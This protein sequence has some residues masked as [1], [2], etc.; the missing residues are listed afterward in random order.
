MHVPAQF[1]KF[2]RGIAQL[3][4]HY[5]FEDD[6]KPRAGTGD[7]ELPARPAR[8]YHSDRHRRYFFAIVLRT[9]S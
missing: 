6:P 8:A 2:R 3:I 1:R 9:V 4:G 7:R 5:I